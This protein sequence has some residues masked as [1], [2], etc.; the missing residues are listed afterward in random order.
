M[1][2]NVIC[3]VHVG[4]PLVEEPD[5]SR[6]ICAKEVTLH[7]RTPSVTIT[8]N[9]SAL[10]HHNSDGMALYASSEPE[11]NG[12][13][14]SSVMQYDRPYFLSGWL[15]REVLLLVLGYHCTQPLNYKC[16]RAGTAR[17]TTRL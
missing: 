1:Y 10:D 15:Q 13:Q 17:Y 2:N 6:P 9:T 5:W 7:T 3:Q 11:Q 14:E 16:M 8:K 12:G 4:S